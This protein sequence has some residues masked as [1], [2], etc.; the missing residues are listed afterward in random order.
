MRKCKCCGGSLMTLGVLGT[1]THVRC[2]DCGMM[3]SF[4]KEGPR[5]RRS[6]EAAMRRYCEADAKLAL[7]ARVKLSAIT[8]TP[9]EDL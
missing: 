3:F 5:K 9:S 2:R 6:A 7:A 8:G 1:L 4:D